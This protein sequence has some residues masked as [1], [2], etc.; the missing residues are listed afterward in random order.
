MP[1]Q[2][3]P[4]TTFAT[5]MKLKLASYCVIFFKNE[6]AHKLCIK[7]DYRI[8]LHHHHALRTPNARF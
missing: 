3:Q 6:M 8:F 7:R 2:M 5:E 4:T 1:D